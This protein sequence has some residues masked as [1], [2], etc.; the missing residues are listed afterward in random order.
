MLP[1]TKY[2]TLTHIDVDSLTWQPVK[3][4]K[5]VLDDITVELNAGEFYGILGPNGAGKT[6][7]VRQIL[8]LQQS[9]SGTVILDQKNI[10]NMS[11][12]EM[13]VKLSF[14]PQNITTD[15]DFSV[16]DVVAMGREPH[17]K[18]FTPLG[19]EDLEKINEALEFTRCNHI[20]DKSISFL[21]GGER[22]RVMIARTIAQDTPW[23]ILDEPVSN[24]DVKHQAEL[25]SV[26]ERLRSE[27]GKTIVAILH[28]INLAASYCT[29]IILMKQGAIFKS[30]ATKEVL[31]YDN[32]CN[33]YDI[34]FDFLERKNGEMPYIVP[35]II[36]ERKPDEKVVHSNG[37]EMYKNIMGKAK[38]HWDSIAKPID[39]LGMLEEN[40]VRICNI[41]QDASYCDITKKALVIMCG[42]H[43]VVS[44]GVTQ[45]GSDVTRIVSE[46]FAKGCSTVN[47]MANVAGAD[48]YTV[49]IGMDTPRYMGKDLVMGG[50]I[51][52]KIAMGTNNLICEAAMTVEQCRS[53]IDLGIDI[54]RDLKA[55]GYKIIA[56]GEMGIGNTTPTSVLAAVFLNLSEKSVTG[57]GAGL[58][59]EGL[60][61][62][63]QVVK[64][65][66][67]RVREKGLSDPLDIM[68]EVGGYELAGMVG[69]YLGGVKYGIPIVIDGAISAVSAL[70]AMKLDGR[71]SDYVIASHKSD[72][73]TGGLAL[74]ALGVTPIIH[75]NL[76][77]GEGTGAVA[78]YPILDMAADVYNKMGSFTDYEI[79]TYERFDE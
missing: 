4:Q 52:R 42:D 63:Y 16:F 8:K 67:D 59:S 64:R 68:A 36:N 44:E 57:R 43:G 33:V 71:V 21:S 34:E 15:V 78:L 22:Q 5:A 32:L 6:S 12:D 75:G 69:I 20:K 1:K 24:L 66:V 60:E 70:C 76:R 77:L 53:A 55:M 25:M 72:E 31:N 30:G 74:E 29:Q 48:V 47:H 2:S 7:I 9:N 79:E 23:I 17:R 35:R 18:S 26:L 56:T 39:S 37:A 51:D 14:L 73:I 46:N 61:R 38:A 58:S 40:I 28:D 54:V 50:V 3:K 62:K 11:R 13:A 41:H 45:T 65:A 10:R 19:E 49:D 27:K